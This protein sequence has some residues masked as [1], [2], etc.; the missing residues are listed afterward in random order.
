MSDAKILIVDDLP[1]NLRL[2]ASILEPEGYCLLMA[3]SGQ[4]GLDVARAERPDIILLD[5]M[6]PDISGTE[7]CR[8][9]RSEPQFKAIPIILITAMSAK[10]HL[11]DGLDAGADD[12]ISK[13]VDRD[14]LLARVRSLLRVKHL[15]DA[16]QDLNDSLDQ[17]VKEQTSTIER[18]TRLKHYVSPDVADRILAGQEDKLAFHRARIAAVCCDLRDYTAFTLKACPEEILAFLQEFYGTLGPMVIERNGTIDHFTG[19]GIL[20]FINDP[21]ECENP[22]LRAVDLAVA[23]RE[24]ASL[25]LQKWRRR[26]F[27]LGFG[28]GVTYGY[29]TV[30]EVGFGQRR[31]YAGI[32]PEINLA[33]RL[34]TCARDGQILISEAV[35]AEVDE[36]IESERLPDQQLK[37]FSA[38]VAVRNVVALKEVRS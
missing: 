10:E 27:R 7:V 5:I 38:P 2:L 11:V 23:L 1:S 29:A 6:M 20:T 37:G 4:D 26:G 17:R 28:V 24:A 3:E 18:L 21:V 36:Q 33:S 22:P 14:E 25:M 13:P 8:E 31:E 32:G 12:F 34:S 15:H 16:L 9:L 30:G 19:D 35:Y